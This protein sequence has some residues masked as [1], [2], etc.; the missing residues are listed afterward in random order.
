MSDIGYRDAEDIIAENVRE[1][2]PLG[3]TPITAT[4]TARF[5]GHVS[6]LVRLRE[7]RHKNF[8]LALLEVEK[9]LVP[10]PGDPP[11]LYPE[12]Q[13]WADLTLRRKK[14]A[15][16]DLARTGGAEAK[17][18]EALDDDTRLEFIETPLDQVV[19]FLKDQHGINI[20][21]DAGELDNVG[22]GTDVPITR[23][24][25]GITLRSAL[26][27][28]LKDLELTYVIRDEVLLITTP[29]EAEAELV[30]KVYPVGDLVLPIQSGMGMGGMGG[31]G[32]FAVEDDLRLE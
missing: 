21:L 6:T 23:N 22:I 14:Y 30:T 8:A 10:F 32:M 28:M 31:G 18:L 20:E 27:L 16:I 17:I 1:L 7:V 5:G 26:R 25:K 12:P 11:I 13:V 2:D 29:E 15:S 3:T 24:L 19:D 4:W 9:A